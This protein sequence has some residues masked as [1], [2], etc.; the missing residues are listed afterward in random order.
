MDLYTRMREFE[1]KTATEWAFRVLN[2]NT[3]GS[4]KM[5]RDLPGEE[6]TDW[7]FDLSSITSG[8]E[9]EVKAAAEYLEWREMLRREVGSAYARVLHAPD[10]IKTAVL[11]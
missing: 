9:D 11:T 2:S 7:F 1:R 6:I 10:E 5:L 8:W 4:P 3:G